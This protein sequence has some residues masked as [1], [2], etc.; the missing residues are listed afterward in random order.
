MEKTFDA[1]KM[2]R[3]IRTKLSRRY[4]RNPDLLWSDLDKVRRKYN[5]PQPQQKTRA[6][7]VAER[8]VEYEAGK[9]SA[10]GWLGDVMCAKSNALFLP[11]R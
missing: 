1:V 10:K 5:Y 4:T 11:M 6:K 8:K 7:V 9:R 3:D 2:M